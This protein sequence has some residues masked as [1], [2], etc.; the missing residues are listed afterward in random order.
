MNRVINKASSNKEQKLF[1]QYLKM[2][3]PEALD[4]VKG[5]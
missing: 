4:A 3:G 5:N 1:I 2:F